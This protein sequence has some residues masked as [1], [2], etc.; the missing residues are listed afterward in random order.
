VRG[1]LGLLDLV[2]LLQLLA[3]N[4]SRGCLAVLHPSGREARVYLRDGRV[5]GATFGDAR[6]VQAVRALLADQRGSFEFL[7]GVAPAT[8]TVTSGLDEFLF[9]AIRALG[10]ST[11]AGSTNGAARVARLAAALGRG[12]AAGTAVLDEA[13]IE[14]WLKQTGGNASRV[15][16]TRQD[17]SSFVLERRAATGVGPQVL[18]ASATMVRYNVSSGDMLDAVPEE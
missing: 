14:T 3:R 12:Q 4:G 2:D 16:L 10:N 6:D 5:V 18:L 9:A 7:P 17:G 11:A 15:R 1:T 13:I 8:E